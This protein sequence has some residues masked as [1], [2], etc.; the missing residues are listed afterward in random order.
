MAVPYAKDSDIY[1]YDKSLKDIG[2]E[3]FAPQLLLASNDVLNLIKGSWWPS[4]TEIPLES[5]D[6]ARLDEDSLVQLTVFKALG[7]YIFP[8]LSKFTETD[9]FKAKAEHY[10]GRFKDEWATIKGLP[11]YDFD[12]NSI[13]DDY[14]KPG[15][16]VHRLSRG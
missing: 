9:T 2:E 13:H 7:D 4:A 16:F 11:L 15:P 6:E 8:G 14:E 10:Q 12:D 1:T 3:S 5:F